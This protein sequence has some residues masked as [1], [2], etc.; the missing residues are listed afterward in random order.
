M[1]AHTHTH[2]LYS[3]FFVSRLFSSYVDTLSLFC[4]VSG[5]Y[6]KRAQG[7]NKHTTE[8]SGRKGSSSSAKVPPSPINPS[9]HKKSSTPS[10]VSECNTQPFR[11]A[12][13]FHHV[14]HSCFYLACETCHLLSVLQ[15]VPPEYEIQMKRSCAFVLFSHV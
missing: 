13:A 14:V 6:S 3:H 15:T 9:D 5:S 4:L 12:R 7:D 10:S 8:E 1:L 11:R 2:T